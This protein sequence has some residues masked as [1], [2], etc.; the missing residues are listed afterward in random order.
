MAP[1]EPG[2]SL[3]DRDLSMPLTLLGL[4][5]GF[6]GL[7]LAVLVM[8]LFFLLDSSQPSSF[9]SGL[10]RTIQGF[11]AVAQPLILTGLLC[12]LAGLAWSRR[13]PA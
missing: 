11:S 3:T 1:D 8:L 9:A 13:T 5:L 4:G 2:A 6:L 7:G 12:V 10:F